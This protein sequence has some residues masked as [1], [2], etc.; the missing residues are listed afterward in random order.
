[1][2][3]ALATCASLDDWIARAAIPFSLGADRPL[4]DA[5]DR[6]MAALGGWRRE[7]KAEPGTLVPL[8]FYGFDSPT[9]MMRTDSPRQL[10][11]VALDYLASIDPTN[12]NA[13]RQRIDALLGD[14]AV[15]SNPAAM[16][17]LTQ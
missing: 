10:L 17:D 9:E 8:R 11:H 16:M 13:R 12:G 14:D 3:D 2:V 6:M 15:W 1:M 7:Y 5:V 4:E